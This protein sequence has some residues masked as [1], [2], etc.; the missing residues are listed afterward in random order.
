M[1]FTFTYYWFGRTEDD[2]G[3]WVTPSPW[4]DP[5]KVMRVFINT[6]GQKGS[7]TGQVVVETVDGKG[8]SHLEGKKIERDG[9]V[10]ILHTEF[11]TTYRI[12]CLSSYDR[13]PDEELAIYLEEKWKPLFSKASILRKLP[14]G[15]QKRAIME[16]YIRQK[17]AIDN[18][19]D[20]QRQRRRAA[21]D[22]GDTQ[23][24]EE[25]KGAIY[26][27]PPITLEFI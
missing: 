6:E 27:L 21:R 7:T 23:A 25:N 11:R 22:A 10:I 15:N 9:W 8:P 26:A 24:E 5:M 12:H 2:G 1:V 4:V 17:E 19:K 3:I 20:A 14:E 16:Y 18:E 13:G